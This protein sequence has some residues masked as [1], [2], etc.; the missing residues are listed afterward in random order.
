MWRQANLPD[1]NEGADRYE[2]SSYQGQVGP[3]RIIVKWNCQ[4]SLAYRT[5]RYPA[6]A[7]RLSNLKDLFPIRR[8]E[9]FC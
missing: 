5:D 1:E 4:H 3:W 6:Q 7:M 2:P 9:H 8:S